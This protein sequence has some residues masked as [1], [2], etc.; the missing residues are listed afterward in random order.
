MQPS[1]EKRE[2]LTGKHRAQGAKCSGESLPA[3][4]TVPNCVRTCRVTVRAQCQ[5]QEGGYNG[6]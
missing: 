5:A 4:L 6:R 1:R 2:R 3:A